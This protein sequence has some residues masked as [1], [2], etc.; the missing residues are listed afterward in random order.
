MKKMESFL[1]AAQRLRLVA[2]FTVLF[3]AD[4]EHP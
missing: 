2:R 4:F 1:Y 3:S